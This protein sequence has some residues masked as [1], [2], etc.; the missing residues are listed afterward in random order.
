MISNNSEIVLDKKE[1]FISQ[2]PVSDKTSEYKRLI[3]FLKKRD[4]RIAYYLQ[5]IKQEDCYVAIVVDNKT[6]DVFGSNVTCMS[7]WCKN[8]T[9]RPLNV[10]E[11]IDNYDEFVVNNNIDEYE[12][13]IKQK[14]IATLLN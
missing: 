10:Q 5:E 8:G 11:F 13:M 6:K 3:T 14:A 4:Y 2:I 1:M 9:R 7:C 12:T